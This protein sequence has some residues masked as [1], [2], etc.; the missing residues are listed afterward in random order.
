MTGILFNLA[1]DVKFCS[2][3]EQLLTEVFLRL[4]FN[5]QK[6]SPGDTLFM[7]CYHFMVCIIDDGS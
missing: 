2:F 3:S 1:D 4:R 6:V 7:L 5:K